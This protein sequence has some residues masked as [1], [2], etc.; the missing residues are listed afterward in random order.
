MATADTIYIR[1]LVFD[2]IIG[3]LPIE[4]T[5]PQPICINLEVTVD[6][7]AA[8]RSRDLKDTLDYAALA[9]AVKH[10]TIK[11]ECLLVE[12]LAAQIAE[13]AL[14]QPMASAVLVDINKPNALADAAGVG[15][16]IY[17]ER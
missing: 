5:T 3:V 13:L 11:A 10:L 9:E 14:A 17:R 15:V 16:R 7:R 8:A 4:R 2:A 6:T 12:T 1:D